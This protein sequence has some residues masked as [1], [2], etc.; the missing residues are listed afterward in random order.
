M[1]PAGTPLK[2]RV[3]LVTGA[4]RGIGA[5]TAER[6]GALGAEVVV[7]YARSEKAAADVAERIRH[8]GSDA[9]TLAAD[10]TGRDAA[11]ALA[12]AAEGWKGR[13]DVLVNN[14]GVIEAAI[15]KRTSD[16]DLLD[17]LDDWDDVVNANLRA[18]FALSARL[19]REMKKRGEGTIVNVA[20]VAGMYAL[21]DAPLYSLTKAGLLHLTRQLAQMYAPQV[22]VNAVAPGWVDT[23]F[24]GG[25]IQDPEFQK[26]VSRHI[27]M[28]RVADPEEVADAI[29]WLVAGGGY[30]TGTTVTV[31]GGMVSELR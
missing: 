19:G 9:T 28:R 1:D 20:S 6:L 16:A 7:H 26:Q 15:D 13:V 12:D 5:A 29:E 27:P 3:A 2:G 4:S 18:P 24:G 31:D 8:G 11:L 30:V 17:H 23:G 14:A 22:R 21:T 10:L 25:F